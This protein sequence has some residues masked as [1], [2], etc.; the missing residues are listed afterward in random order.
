MQLAANPVEFVLLHWY[1]GLLVSF[2][3]KDLVHFQC[4]W[5]VVALSTI[6][7]GWSLHVGEPTTTVSLHVLH[8]NVA[9][10]AD[11]ETTRMVVSVHGSLCLVYSLS[12][13]VAAVCQ[14][15]LFVYFLHDW[16]LIP[17]CL[18]LQSRG[19]GPGCQASPLWT[20]SLTQHAVCAEASKMTSSVTIQRMCDR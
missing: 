9:A 12:M 10:M 16:Q 1:R 4:N 17:C 15:P 11:C 19:L 6:V 3:C 2:P 8:K 18:V 5:L 7:Q 14:S 20:Y 13:W